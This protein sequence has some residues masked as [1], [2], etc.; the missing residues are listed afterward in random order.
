[1]P[2]SII[3]SLDVVVRSVQFFDTCSDP[4][5]FCLAAY[6]TLSVALLRGDIFQLM[7]VLWRDLRGTQT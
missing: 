2:A 4:F 6:P 3:I 1:M 5:V 7:P